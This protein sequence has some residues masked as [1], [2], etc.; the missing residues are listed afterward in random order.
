MRLGSFGMDGSLVVDLFDQLR[1]KD[2]TFISYGSAS[3]YLQAGSAVRFEVGYREMRPTYQ[4]DLVSRERLNRDS[5]D[6]AVVA[7]NAL[8]GNASSDLD[9]IVGGFLERSVRRS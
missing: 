1:D 5:N 2:K 8:A 4:G 9:P 3:A 6:P 7:A